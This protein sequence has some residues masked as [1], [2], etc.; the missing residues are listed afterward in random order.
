M[1]RQVTDNLFKHP[2]GTW[3]KKIKGKCYYFGADEQQAYR[4]WWEDKPYLLAGKLP[5]RKAVSAESPTV[6]ELGNVY[7]DHQ[8]KQLAAGEIGSRHARLC[9]STIERFIGIVGKSRRID[10]LTPLDW[11]DV[12]GKLFEPIPRTKPVRGKVFG[13]TVDRRSNE[14]VAG[15]VR[16]IRSF[17]TWCAD[18]KLIPHPDW[19]KLFRPSTNT[20]AVAY[21]D[22]NEFEIFEPAELRAIIDAASVQFRPLLLLA[23]NGGIGQ[24]DI[25]A[26]TVSGM[27]KLTADGDGAFLSLPRLKT[28]NKRR[29][30]LWPETLAAIEEYRTWRA[31]RKGDKTS[32]VFFLT[33]TGQPWVRVN[34]DGQVKDSVGTTFRRLRIDRGLADGTFYDLRRG[35]QTVAGETLDFL[36]VKFVMGHLK[37]KKSRDMSERYT[38]K[39]GDD[40]VRRVCEHVHDWLYGV[41]AKP[42]RKAKSKAVANG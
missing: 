14:T 13:R 22:D 21:D 15:E 1:A 37:P 40:R 41:K 31:K 19:G 10:T 38:R 12:K 29:V 3:A 4:Q 34:G 24:T 36:A 16:R 23:A 28:G 33:A 30:W 11:S 2:N 42:K 32:P 5:P 17:V 35:F 8:A 20:S 27:D 26:M 9:R 7:A 39:V 18:A 6:V 25:A